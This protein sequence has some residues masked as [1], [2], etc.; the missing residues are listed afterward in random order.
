MSMQDDLN[1]ICDGFTP[2]M[3]AEKSREYHIEFEALV[4]EE[5]DKPY[6]VPD[7]DDLLFRSFI[8]HKVAA[9]D[10]VLAKLVK[11]HEEN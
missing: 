8:C 2:E 3:V 9:M 10:L 6:H 7:S 11:I 5:C 1:A 4:E